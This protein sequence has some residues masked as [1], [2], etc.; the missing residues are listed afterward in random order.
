MNLRMI[1]PALLL[2]TS[3]NGNA[4]VTAR[5]EIPYQRSYGYPWVMQMENQGVGALFMA[6]DNDKDKRLF[7][8]MHYGTNLKLIAQDS[9]HIDKKMDFESYRY[10]DGNLYSFMRNREDLMIVKYDTKTHK[11]SIVNGNF[12]KKGDISNSFIKNDYMVFRSVVKKV[13]RLGFMN[14]KTGDC[15]F[16]DL[17]FDKVK[18]R[19]V[20]IIETMIVDHNAYA[21]VR[22]DQELYLIKSTLQGKELSR[23]CLTTEMEEQILTASI[24]KVNNELLMTGTYSLDRKGGSN[25]VYFAQLG[26]DKIK[27]I[28]FYNFLDLSHFTDFMSGRKQKKMERK[29]EK[30]EKH[31]KELLLNCNILCHDVKKVGDSYFFLGEAYQPVYHTVSTGMG[32][33]TYFAGYK[34]THSVLMK[35]DKNGNKLWDACFE[36]SSKELAPYLRARV[37]LS[38]QNNNVNCVFAD[39]GKL[40]SKLF[41]NKDGK[42]LQ[43]RQTNMIEA[44]DEN[45]D[46]KKTRTARCEHWYD[47]SFI[48]IGT[49]IVKKAGDRIKLT[50][51][52][53]YSI[54]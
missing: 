48:V 41:S 50:Y 49:Q 7:K 12:G 37:A 9:I 44:T 4:Q 8:I 47:N 31:G 38:I 26:T 36:M 23:I 53:K 11:Q 21:L 13:D 10:S 52:N 29:K 35:F 51:L 24:C 27:S 19:K 43:D 20:F 16:N 6:K 46:V 2:L 25:G 34:Y 32:T 3:V 39:R 22:A 17:H 54:K 1:L 33:T 18:D 40:V 5:A 45:E 42:V 28:K 30:A 15:V 14:L